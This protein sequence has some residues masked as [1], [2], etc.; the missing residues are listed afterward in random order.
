M[1]GRISSMVG[2]GRGVGIAIGDEEVGWNVRWAD[3]MG[4]GREV[5]AYVCG[6]S[7]L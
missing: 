1:E 6:L 5:G 3:G 2:M 7:E 4:V